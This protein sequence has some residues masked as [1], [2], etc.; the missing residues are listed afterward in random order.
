MIGNKTEIRKIICDSNK[1]TFDSYMLKKSE[2]SMQDMT[3]YARAT[4]SVST[5]DI[6]L[7]LYKAVD[8]VGY[9]KSYYYEDLKQF[10]NNKT[11]ELNYVKSLSDIISECSEKDL[12]DTESDC[13]NGYIVN[14]ID[15]F[16]NYLEDNDI[17]IK[18][19]VLDLMQE[20]INQL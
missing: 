3:N 10:I 1:E 5:R 14:Y 2:I 4:K 6:V 19:D 8:E 12:L 13:C 17:N 7:W 11:I 9:D 20:R 16:C 18:N 15:I